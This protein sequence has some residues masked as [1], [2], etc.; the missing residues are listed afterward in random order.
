MQARV[1]SK[2]PVVTQRHILLLPLL[3]QGFAASFQQDPLRRKAQLQ[4]RSQPGGRCVP[5]AGF[6]P[7]A[8]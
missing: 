1:V 6:Q 2:Q 7:E 4:T 3:V 5:G 8:S